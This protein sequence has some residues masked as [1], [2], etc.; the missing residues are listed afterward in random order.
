VSDRRHT[1]EIPVLLPTRDECGNCVV[2]LRET[3]EQTRGVEEV[4]PAERGGSLR[5]HFDPRLL[6]VRAL[7][8]RARDACGSIAARY[9]HQ[10]LVLGGLDCAD[11]AR[12]V[13][14]AVIRRPGVLYASVNF[15]TSRLFLEFDC[16]QIPLDDVMHDVRS[17][18]YQVW[19]D[20][21]YRAYRKAA[22]PR[23]FYLRNRRALQTAASFA[24]LVVGSVLWLTTAEPH[25]LAIL[26]L[27]AAIVVGGYPVA[28]NGINIILRTHN[29][30]MNVLM[31]VAVLGAAAVG[32]WV[33]AALVVALFG[34]GETLERWAVERT[35]GSIQ[36]LM[37]M[38]PEEAVL[39]HDDREE[40]VPV[41]D[42]QV[43]QI[44]VVKPGARIPLDGAV[45]K[46]SSAV[47]ESPITGESVP[48]AKAQN[49]LVYAG[50][51]NQR[52]SLE[53]RVDART[54]HRHG[55]GSPGPEG[56]RRT[57]G[58]RLRPLLHAHRDGSGPGHGRRPAGRGRRRL[59]GLGVPGAHSAHP[60]LSVRTRDLHARQHR[61]G[62]RGGRPAGRPHQRRRA[63]GGRRSS[64]RGG[65][66]QDRHPHRRPSPR[67]RRGELQ[68]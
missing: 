48:R 39:R 11:C 25:S 27:V 56:P 36:D 31:T 28:R 45:V 62:H 12:S 24:L 34:L 16:E 65:V 33:E 32:A 38:S 51:I 64:R 14:R 60:S 58:G 44:V 55:G 35:R 49:D 57:V 41:E 17:L 22:T 29:V 26:A 61:L 63:P 13:E 37:D 6:T 10:S 59:G 20:D 5:V 53:V 3:I 1:V 7:E 67:D 50:T 30:D 4:E 43:G 66:R 46:G 47:D 21:E 42:V 52:G 23:P 54:A 2:R 8:E 18:G 40:R 19:T 15:A 9:C 68:R